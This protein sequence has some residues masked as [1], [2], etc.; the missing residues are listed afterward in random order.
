[1]NDTHYD[2]A[3]GLALGIQASRREIM[4]NMRMPSIEQQSGH[5]ATIALAAE[6]IYSGFQSARELATAFNVSHP[7][8]TIY[9]ANILLSFLS[10]PDSLRAAAV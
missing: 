8:S 10:L 6:V 1:V 9:P 4:R 7:Q 2:V 5:A 3:L